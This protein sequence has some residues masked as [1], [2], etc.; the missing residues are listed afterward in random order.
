VT[1]S[2]GNGGDVAACRVPLNVGD[3]IVLGGIH[4]LQVCIEL[5]VAL[6]RLF[7]G[8]VKRHVP[9]LELKRLLRLESSNHDEASLGRPVN[10][11]GVLL[12]HGANVSEIARRTA[13][14]LFGSEERHCSLGAHGGALNGFASGD[15]DEAVALG[16]PGKVDDGVL[17]GIDDFDG[18]ALFADTEDFEIGGEGLF[19]LGVTVDLDTDIGGF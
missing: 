2:T 8:L 11:I 13:L 6:F 17:D 16:L 19:R 7:L 14:E 1:E 10:G 9:K 12:V 3:T 18:H 5:L 4:E 15:E